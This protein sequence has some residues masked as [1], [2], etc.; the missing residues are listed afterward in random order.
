MNKP[1]E[2]NNIPA[3]V[4]AISEKVLRF[5]G[6]ALPMALLV[7]FVLGLMAVAAWVVALIEMAVR[8]SVMK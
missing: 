8:M 1:S 5:V 4:I 3:F 7:G 6:F 2:L